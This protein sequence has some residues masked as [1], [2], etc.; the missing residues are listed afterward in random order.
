M[1]IIIIIMMIIKR[2]TL[3][4]SV[5]LFLSVPFEAFPT[6]ECRRVYL[7]P[8]IRFPGP[9]EQAEPWA[10]DAVGR[11]GRKGAGRAGSGARAA[12]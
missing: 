6:Q 7:K 5:L 10:P 9:V 2:C 8:H 1:K 11:E 12:A 4:Q 3:S